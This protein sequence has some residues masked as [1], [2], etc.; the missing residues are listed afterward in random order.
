MEHFVLSEAR[1]APSITATQAGDPAGRNLQQ[2]PVI[3]VVASQRAHRE[4]L[5]AV[6]G[7][8]FRL[9][10]NALRIMTPKRLHRFL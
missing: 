4:T 7:R 3:V 8:H 1:P 9:R 10:D 6:L 2:R 5:R